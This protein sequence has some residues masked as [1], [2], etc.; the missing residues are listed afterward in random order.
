Q[1]ETVGRPAMPIARAE[2]GDPA[3]Q[4]AR[5]RNEI[6]QGFAAARLIADGQKLAIGGKTMIVIALLGETGIDAQRFYTV[7]GQA[8]YVAARKR[9]RRVEAWNGEWRSSRR[10]YWWS[11]W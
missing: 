10:M 2:R 4:A 9:D 7:H 3:G 6:D 1:G 5:Q 11:P 8:V